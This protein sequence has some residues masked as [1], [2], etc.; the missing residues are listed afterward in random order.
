MPSDY[1]HAGG[2][3]VRITPTTQPTQQPPTS[4][5]MARYIVKVASGGQIASLLL[6]LS[7]SQLCSALLDTVKSRL[8]TVASQLGLTTLSDLH[9][10][11]HLNSERG[12]ML[13]I[14]DLLS[15]ILPDAQGTIYAVVE[16][17]VSDKFTNTRCQRWHER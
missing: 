11:L 12:P 4:A 5:N 7:P 10:T 1:K 6:V 14:E 17:K 16:N 9:I 2:A 13:D 8:P 15:D 3:C